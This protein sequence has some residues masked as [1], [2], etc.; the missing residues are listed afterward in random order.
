MKLDLS[1]YDYD[2]TNNDD[3]MGRFNSQYFLVIPF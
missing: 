3:F 1:V 2:M